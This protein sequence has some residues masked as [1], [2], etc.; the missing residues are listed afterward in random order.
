MTNLIKRV[1]G[2][3]LGQVHIIVTCVCRCPISHNSLSKYNYFYFCFQ[4]SRWNNDMV[5]LFL[6]KNIFQS[7]LYW[8][9]FD[10]SLHYFF[11]QLLIKRKKREQPLLKNC[12]MH[13]RHWSP[14]S[15]RSA[16]VMRSQ[17]VM[18]KSSLFTIFHGCR[19]R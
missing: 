14:Y 16:W 12:L 3:K 2:L 9:K 7:R 10:Y 1:L 18:V 15:T 4:A 13:K 11:S 17:Q 8:T 6:Y 5:A 19:M